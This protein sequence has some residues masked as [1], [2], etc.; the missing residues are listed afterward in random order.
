MKNSDQ[1][2]ELNINPKHKQTRDQSTLELYL[3]GIESYLCSC[4][5][6]EKHFKLDLSQNAFPTHYT[7]PKNNEDHFKEE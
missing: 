6:T 5:Y 1:T 4:V 3:P 2:S 7:M